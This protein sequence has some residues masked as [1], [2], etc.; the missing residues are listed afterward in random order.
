MGALATSRWRSPSNE[1]F[2]AGSNAETADKNT[3][4]QL[5]RRIPR[6]YFSRLMD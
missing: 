4:T 1:T 2:P 6:A 5:L 3:R